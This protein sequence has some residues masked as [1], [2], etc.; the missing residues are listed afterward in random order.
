MSPPVD[1]TVPTDDPGEVR[2][3]IVQGLVVSRAVI[4][5]VVSIVVGEE[6]PASRA[7]MEIDIKLHRVLEDLDSCLRLM[8]H[9][10]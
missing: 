9:G 1:P 10:G 4:E 2:M 3:A 8:R 6:V 5:E 7:Q